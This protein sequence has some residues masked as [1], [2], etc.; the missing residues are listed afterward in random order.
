MI[1]DVLSEAFDEIE[2]YQREMPE[3]YI[4][5]PV[6]EEIEQ[7]KAELPTGQLDFPS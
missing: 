4:Y 5:P 6:H 7:V 3:V 1:S 2:R